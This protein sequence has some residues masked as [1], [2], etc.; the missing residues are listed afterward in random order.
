[1]GPILNSVRKTG[2]VV[3]VHE[4]C[5]KGGFGAE[6]AAQIQEEAFNELKSPVLRVGAPNVPVPFAVNLER[7]YVPEVATILR[8]V[9]TCLQYQC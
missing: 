7:S 2:R 1:M 5:K 4:A 9:Q 3:V 6:L 8:A